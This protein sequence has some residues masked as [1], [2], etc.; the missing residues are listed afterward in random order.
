MAA[1][2]PEQVAVYREYGYVIVPDLLTQEEVSAFVEEQAAPQPQ[3]W[4]DLGLRRHTADPHWRRLATHPSVTAIVSQLI[5]GSPEVVQTMYMPKQEG[6]PGV[7]LHQDTHY[8]RAEPNTLMAC[9][10]AFAD[11]DRSNGGLCVV[12]GSHKRPLYKTALPKD[13]TEHGRWEIICPMR[14]PNGEEWDEPM[15]AH[16]VQG[17]DPAELVFLAVPKGGVVFFTGTTVHGSFA[18][19]R[20][21]SLRLAFATHYVKHGTWVYRKD[22]QE[23]VPV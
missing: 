22:I 21:D 19:R 23:T 6:G 9:W 17:L 1:L 16:E 7:A 14:A 15:H 11:S 5:G 12:P 8:I 13:E 2:T 20:A 4:R 3:A 18:N 10:I